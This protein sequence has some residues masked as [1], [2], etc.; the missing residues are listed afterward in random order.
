MLKILF[1]YL[2]LSL[3]LVF[4]TSIQFIVVAQSDIP[5]KPKLETS[6]YDGAHMITDAQKNLLEQKLINYSDSTSTQIVVATVNTINGENI[7]LYAT[8]WAHEWGIG[9]KDKDNGVFLL[10]AKNDRKLTIRS[11]YGV[12]HK[13]TDALSKRI[14]E[15]VITPRFKEGN[16]F[17]GLD[18]GTTAIIQI[19][20]GEF[21]DNST[22]STK[23]TKI[24]IGMIIFFFIILLYILSNRRGG[25]GNRGNRRGRVSRTLLDAIILSSMGRGGFGGGSS[26]NSGGGFGSGGFGGGF[27]GGGFGGGG[28]SGGW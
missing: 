21:E 9:Q 25:K 22:K 7:A 28:A 24:P 3:A 19:L 8:E 5:P 27:G 14:I 18:N 15:N 26:G 1:K 2:K 13:L 6:V 23:G 12:E 10:V 20:N 16:F 11:G 4:I 17:A